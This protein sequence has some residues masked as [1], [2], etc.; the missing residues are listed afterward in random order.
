MCKA[1]LKPLYLGDGQSLSFAPPAGQGADS[2]VSDPAKPIPFVQRP[3]RM[4]DR[5]TWTTWLVSDQRNAAAR[6]DVLSFMTA[7]L[8]QDVVISGAP[9]MRFF[10]STTGTDIDWVVK[11]IDVYPDETPNQPE[12]GG[13]QLPVS[14]DIFRGRYRESTEFPKAIPANTPLEWRISLPNANHRFKAGHRIM[15]QMQSTLF[16]LYDRNPQTFVPNIFNAK[17]EDYKAATQTI[18]H[19]PGKLSAILLPVVPD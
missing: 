14:L 2:Y 7:P 18:L 13:Y 10:A 12:L 1:P 19:G 4:E 6:P 11:L 9:V 3:I 16:P 5:P 17:P 15:V 8:E